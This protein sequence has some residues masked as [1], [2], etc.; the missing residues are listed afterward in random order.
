MPKDKVKKLTDEEALEYGASR[1]G[2]PTITETMTGEQVYSIPSSAETYK[3]VEPA[4]EKETKEYI[5]S[6]GFSSGGMCRG[7]GKAI[8]GMKFG[9]VK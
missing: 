4:L 2:S 7:G 5:Q 6:R 1:E 8:R 3:A 9:G